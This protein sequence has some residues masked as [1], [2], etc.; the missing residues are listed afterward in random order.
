MATFESL[1]QELADSCLSAHGLSSFSCSVYDTAWV[2]MISKTVAGTPQWLFPASFTYILN[3]QGPDGGWSHSSASASDLDA[4]L[5]TMAALLALVKHSHAQNQTNGNV[6]P[7]MTPDLNERI[8]RATTFLRE[9]LQTWD[10]TAAKAHVG[11]EILVPAHQRYLAAEGIALNFPGEAHLTK[12]CN[13]KFGLFSPELLYGDKLTSLT[14]SLEALAG[15]I[16]FD[17]VRHRLEFGSMLASPA[18]TAAYLIHASSWDDDAEAYIRA[19]AEFGMGKG[20]GAVP[21]AF[22]T[23]LFEMSWV[24]STILQ[25]QD[26]SNSPLSERS[27]NALTTVARYLQG[28]FE[29]QDGVVGFA[30]GVI[31]DADDTARVILALNLSGCPALPDR[32]IQRFKKG[33]RFQTYDRERDPSFSTNC[34][35]LLALLHAPDPQLYSAEIELALHFLYLHHDRGD[36]RDKWNAS[37]LYPRMLLVSALVKLLEVWKGGYGPLQGLADDCIQKAPVVLSAI[38]QRTIH[39]QDPVDGSWGNGSCEVTAYAILALA[40]ISTSFLGASMRNKLRTSIIYGRAFLEAKS[41]QWED[42]DAIWIE[43]IS[44]SSRLLAATYCAAAMQAPI[45]PTT[46]LVG[47]QAHCHTDLKVQVA[48]GHAGANKAKGKGI[49]IAMSAVNEA[50]KFF[51]RLPLFTDIPVWKLTASLV[52]GQLWY[53]RLAAQRHSIFPRDKMTADKYLH[54]IPQTW[55]ACNA[56]NGYPL[57]PGLIWEMMETSRLNYQVDEFLESV[58]GGCDETERDA[59]RAFVAQICDLGAVGDA[60][61]FSSSATDSAVNKCSI[62]RIST[63]L[64]PRITDPLENFIFYIITHPAVTSSPRESQLDLAREL[65]AFLLAHIADLASSHE[66]TSQTSYSTTR[67]TK[68]LSPPSSYYTWVTTT[69][70]NHT[71]CPYSF[72]FFLCLMAY[73]HQGEGAGTKVAGQTPPVLH[74]A[75]QK[76]LFASLT[77]HLSTLC[78]QYNDYGSIL[79]DREEGTLNSVNFPELWEHMAPS[80]VRACIADSEPEQP[81]EQA[82]KDD[83]MWIAE[84]ERECCHRALE[85]LLE[86]SSLDERECRVLRTFVDVTELYGQIYVARDIASRI[87]RG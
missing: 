80:D 86:E 39:E 53:P 38:L 32:L 28:I 43:K 16:E 50:S 85:K 55:T 76:Y 65:K 1:L 81:D 59:V 4:I 75:R 40:S 9:R 2:S 12:L 73:Y 71:S 11:F 54:Y 18:S 31:V 45:F 63:N 20:S 67:P 78:R 33:D 10:P 3:T 77:R 41:S 46:P 23:T 26:P 74:G 48:N 49:A 61:S 51:S 82:M 13:R 83:L 17:R 84:Y 79:R 44:Y 70:A 56:K 24:A 5:N 6:N 34:N 36:L 37:L 27:Q 42:G 15:R 25:V 52:E 60:E 30:P 47:K 8:S 62:I 64:P 66:L 87:E 72:R 21:S 57:A 22:P 69:S 35:V 7:T 29:S 14:H 58:V 19:A 68:Y